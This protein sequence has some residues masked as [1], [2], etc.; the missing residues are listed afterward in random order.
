[1]SMLLLLCALL[2]EAAGTPLLKLSQGLTTLVASLLMIPCYALSFLFLSLALKRLDVGLVGRWDCF[3]HD[4]WHR[5]VQGAS[6]R[7]EDRRVGLDHPRCPRSE[8]ERS[9]LKGVTVSRPEQ[10]CYT[11]LS[12]S[13]T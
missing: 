1:M 2:A 13:H 12:V 5:V 10:V 3:N 7:H 8:S 6:D 4:H 9:V 11:R